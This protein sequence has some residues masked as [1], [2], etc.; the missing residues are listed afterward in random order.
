MAE[1]EPGNAIS[2]R[3]TRI[4]RLAKS[5][6]KRGFRHSYMA[7]Q[8][9]LFLAEQI[10][11]LRG[12]LTQKQFGEK[13]GKPQSVISRVE[14]QA[15]KNISIQTLIDIAEKLDIAVIIR[16]VDFV[17]FLRY[18]EDYSDAALVPRAYEQ[19]AIDELARDTDRRAGEGALKAIFSQPPTQEIGRSAQEAVR[20]DNQLPRQLERGQSL[21][22][23]VP[24]NDMVQ[25]N[26]D[27][28]ISHPG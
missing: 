4:R 28:L 24:A 25:E 18:T 3:L 13:I 15:D 27:R 9:K 6:G 1:Q 16:F 17:T 7:R 19:A 11:A 8:L 14:K 5:F 20:A 2:R 23:P 21:R 26:G 12:D 10:R 22:L